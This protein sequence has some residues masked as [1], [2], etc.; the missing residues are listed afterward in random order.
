[1]VVPRSRGP[2]SYTPSSREAFAAARVVRETGPPVAPKRRLLDRVHDAIRARHYSRR[3]EKAYVAW[4]RRY[5]IFHGKRH[6]VGM[7]AAEITHFLSALAGQG[8]VA[9]ST[10]NQALSAL[11][12]PTATCWSRTCPGSTGWCARSGRSAFPPWHDDDLQHG[13]GWVELPIA[14][15]LGAA[16]IVSTLRPPAPPLILFGLAAVVLAAAWFLAG[17]RAWLA[18]IDGLHLTRFVGAYFLYLYGLGQCSWCR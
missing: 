12:F 4:I 1:M 3:T 9:A 17:F 16:G 6:P 2:I 13:A 11:L 14:T 7:G 18:A 5:I 15:A 10:Q 8:G